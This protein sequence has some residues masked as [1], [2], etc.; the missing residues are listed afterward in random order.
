MS[1]HVKGVEPV[2]VQTARCGRFNVNSATKLKFRGRFG[3]SSPSN[4]D[5]V[6][7]RW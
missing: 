6:K 3:D 4:I 1:P 7:G 2:V 5:E